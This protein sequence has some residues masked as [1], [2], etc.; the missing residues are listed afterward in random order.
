MYITNIKHYLDKAGNIPTSLPK[1]ERELASFLALIVDEATNVYPEKICD[2]PIR[3]LN[4]EC[5]SCI[6]S[7]FV[8]DDKVIYWGCNDCEYDGIISDWQKSRWDNITLLE[9][10]PDPQWVQFQLKTK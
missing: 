7:E 8:Q 3:C 5:T 6:T 10:T 9:G 4:P 1:E 2:T